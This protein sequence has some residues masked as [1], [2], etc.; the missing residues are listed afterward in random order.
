MNCF[1]CSSLRLFTHSLRSASVQYVSQ[2][3]LTDAVAQ[4]HCRLSIVGS[5]SWAEK[6]R[7]YFTP[8]SC[9]FLQL[10]S[11]T[12]LPTWLSVWGFLLFTPSFPFHNALRCIMH[13][14]CIN[15]Y[16]SRLEFS[17]LA[18]FYFASEKFKRIS[19]LNC[20]YIELRVMPQCVARLLVIVIVLKRWW[21]Q[22]PVPAAGILTFWQTEKEMSGI[23][24][25]FSIVFHAFLL[26]LHARVVAVA[27][28]YI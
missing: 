16:V 17:F 15:I 26:T 28:T 19:Y 12:F 6:L 8:L 11:S 23:S 24:L 2:A 4:S 5:L 3:F 27:K 13:I 10:F 25:T 1:C 20:V 9:H 22:A 18:F 7:I 14:L 21:A